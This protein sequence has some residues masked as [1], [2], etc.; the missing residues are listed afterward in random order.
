MSD[1][2][3]QTPLTHHSSLITHHFFS[4]FVRVNP[5]VPAPARGEPRLHRTREQRAR[6]GQ[7]ALVQE[8]HGQ[9][10]TREILEQLARLAPRVDARQGVS[11]P[12][13]VAAQE[14]ARRKVLPGVLLQTSRVLAQTLHGLA[15]QTMRER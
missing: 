15:R 9:L 14:L 12:V 8:V 7:P 2:L 6:D 5:E 1:E 13:R 11:S 10:H 4:S 3:K